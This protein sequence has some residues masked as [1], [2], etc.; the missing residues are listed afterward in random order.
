MLTNILIHAS[1]SCRSQHMPSC[2]SSTHWLED[3]TRSLQWRH[4]NINSKVP[5]GRGCNPKFVVFIHVSRVD[6]SR[7]S[8]AMAFKGMPRGPVYD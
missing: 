4:I 3:R 2:L 1:D 7:N 5:G 6:I 8:C